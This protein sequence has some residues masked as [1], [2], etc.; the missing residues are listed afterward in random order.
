MRTARLLVIAFVMTLGFWLLSPRAM[1][2]PVIG[3]VVESAGAEQLGITKDEYKFQKGVEAVLVVVEG[4]KAETRTNIMGWFWFTDLPDGVYNIAAIKDG[5]VTV[6]KQVRV[7]GR[8]PAN[9]TI[10]LTK[11][12][13]AQISSANYSP[14]NFSP[15]GQ[16]TI[17]NSVYV[18]FAAIAA[19]GSSASSPGSAPIPGSNMSSLQ[20]KG[21]L[22]AGA[23]PDS[24]TGFRSPDMNSM[25]GG[26]YDFSTPVS[27]HPNSITVMDPNAPKD[28]KFINL[29]AKPFWMCFDS[30]GSKLFVSSDSQYIT[31]VDV[32]GGNRI[33]GSIP[34]GGI[35]T[36]MTRGPD[37]NIYVSIS[38]ANPGVM[39]ISPQTNTAVSFFKVRAARIGADA[40]PRALVAGTDLVYVA[41]AKTG[42]GEVVAVNKAGGA[43]VGSSEVGSFP[44]GI[45][46]TPNGQHL[47]IANHGSG[48]VSVIETASMK[49]L[50]K[51]RVGVQPMRIVCN[52]RG[53]RVYVTNNGSNYVSVIDARTGAVVASVNTGKGPMGIGINGAGTRIFVANNKEGNVTIIN[54]EVNQAI[55]TTTASTASNPFGI[56]I[57]P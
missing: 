24:L 54:T 4:V 43:M 40:Q 23:D 57:R 1:A 56:A 15:S 48:D 32:A 39:V 11:K 20:F 51:I 49:H 28:M 6:T 31:V 10:V 41:M 17:P 7:Q 18:A 37:G 53:D 42:A 13:T 26:A 45:T 19:P 9:V 35:V 12:K 2:A 50:G 21:A 55:Q 30:S 8:S 47:F 44:M 25:P 34:S 29:N 27:N 14:G 46:L 38:S 36:D 16:V 22:A 33:M 52:S 5:Y 3:Y